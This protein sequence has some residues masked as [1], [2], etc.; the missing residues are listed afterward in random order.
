MYALYTTP[1]TNSLWVLAADGIQIRLKSE[2]D[3]CVN[4]DSV[5]ARSVGDAS[6]RLGADAIVLLHWIKENE[7]SVSL[8]S[9]NNWDILNIKVVV[10][11][12]NTSIF[13]YLIKD[14]Y[15]IAMF[16]ALHL[17]CGD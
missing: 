10:H 8:N 4:K 1:R 6:S 15:E 7:S 11:R 12:I 5:L 13:V 9:I 2:K 16:I 3:V 14:R 17:P